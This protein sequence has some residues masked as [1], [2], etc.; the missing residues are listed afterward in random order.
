MALEMSVF[1]IETH[2]RYPSRCE[3]CS[4]MLLL[5]AQTVIII[6]TAIIVK[7]LDSPL[8]MT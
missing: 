8:V 2:G 6:I 5:A 3:K 4:K 1:C 7:N